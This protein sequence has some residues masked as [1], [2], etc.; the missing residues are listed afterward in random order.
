MGI[1]P[2]E[3]LSNFELVKAMN[4][5]VMALNDEDAV[6]PWFYD[7][8]DGADDDELMEIAGDAELMDGICSN[9]KRRMAQGSKDGWFTQP[10][11]EFRESFGKQERSHVYGA[12][13][14]G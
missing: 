2:K 8:P 4:T 11:D 3:Q 5:V 7:Y 6:E 13:K 1:G 10:Y 12:R 9:F 14:E